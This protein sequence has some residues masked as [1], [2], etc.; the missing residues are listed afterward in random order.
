MMDKK[1][2]SSIVYEWSLTMDAINDELPMDY[3]WFYR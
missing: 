1:H 2:R 3:Q